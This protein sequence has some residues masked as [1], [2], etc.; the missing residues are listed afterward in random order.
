MRKRVK[1]AVF[2][3]FALM[4]PGAC[5]APAHLPS[6]DAAAREVITPGLLP[7]SQVIARMEAQPAQPAL[8]PGLEARAAA[9]NA[10]AAQLRG[11]GMSAADRQAML[12]M[13]A[14]HR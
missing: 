11:Q 13:Q 8:V 4:L 2:G 14:R 5:F 12:A 10:R 1:G 9:L 6:E 3:A 7:L